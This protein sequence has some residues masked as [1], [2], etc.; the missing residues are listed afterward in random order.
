MPFIKNSQK[1]EIIIPREVVQ[2]ERTDAH[3]EEYRIDKSYTTYEIATASVET[4]KYCNEEFCNKLHEKDRLFTAAAVNGNI[5]ILRYSVESGY[6]LFPFI[7]V[8]DDSDD[9]DENS[10]NDDDDDE[11]K[12]EIVDTDKIAAKG[13][14]NVLKYPKDQFEPCTWL[15]KFC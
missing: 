9:N 7:H 4:A 10:Y 2:K 6:D 11:D 13:N 3:E 12:H 15:Q 8:H 1:R 14:L 5:D